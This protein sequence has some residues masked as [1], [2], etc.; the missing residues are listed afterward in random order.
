MIKIRNKKKNKID[1]NVKINLRN[2]ISVILN[3]ISQNATYFLIV[4]KSKEVLGN[5]LF[6][7]TKQFE[8]D[9]R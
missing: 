4:N 2:N 5:Y 8:V 1:P 9:T 7:L 6:V 3:I